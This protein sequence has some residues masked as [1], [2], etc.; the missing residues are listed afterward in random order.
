MQIPEIITNYVAALN[1]HDPD[2]FAAL[3]A[4]DAVFE[5]VV[6]DGLVF[7]GREEIRGWAVANIHAAPDFSIAT[8][9]VLVER[10]RIAWAWR[11]RAT[12]TGQYPGYPAG[13]GQ[14]IALRVFALIE[15]RDGQIARETHY[16]DNYTFLSQTGALS[17]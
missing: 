6:K 12:Y 17:T 4:E 3:H 7:R 9:S 2:A 5:Q 11:Y 1:A 13:H 14:P 15:L 8:E 10:E 16:F